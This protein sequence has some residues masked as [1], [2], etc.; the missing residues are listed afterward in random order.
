MLLAWLNTGC[1]LICTA[2]HHTFNRLFEKHVPAGTK[3]FIRRLTIQV[4]KAEA[5]AP[6]L[7]SNR[8]HNELE[9]GEQGWACVP[10]VET[11]SRLTAMCAIYLNPILPPPPPP[12]CCCCCCAAGVGVGWQRRCKTR[13]SLRELEHQGTVF[14]FSRFLR[15]GGNRDGGRVR[16]YCAE[17]RTLTPGKGDDIT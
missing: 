13:L 9:V 1:N 14:L 12:R 11:Y 8:T 4:C 10:C 3:P 17:W 5:T 15:F 2:L 6:G 16:S 7:T